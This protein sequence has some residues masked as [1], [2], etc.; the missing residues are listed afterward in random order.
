[1]LCSATGRKRPLN[2]FTIGKNTFLPSV[3]W[4]HTLSQS[5]CHTAS[6]WHARGAP[7]TALLMMVSKAHRTAARQTGRCKTSDRNGAT[8]LEKMQT[9]GTCVDALS[10]TNK[11]IWPTFWYR[12]VQWA[13][14]SYRSWKMYLFSVTE[15]FPWLKEAGRCCH[16]WPYKNNL[17]FALRATFSLSWTKSVNWVRQV[18]VSTLTPTMLHLN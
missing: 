2:T 17:F 14:S 16:L 5:A 13:G 7:V 1:M 12:Y 15:T 11:Y 10:M 3:T 6:R 8:S 9:D 4:S 18:H